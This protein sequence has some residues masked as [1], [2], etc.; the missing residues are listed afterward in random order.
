[1]RVNISS[2]KSINK[3][4]EI[5]FNISTKMEEGNQHSKELNELKAQIL[6][7]RAKA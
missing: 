1:M 6:N 2:L 5:Y 3:L 4:K 7:A